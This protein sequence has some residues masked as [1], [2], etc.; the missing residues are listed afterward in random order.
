VIKQAMRKNQKGREKLKTLW[1]R[2]QPALQL[3]A[4]FRHAAGRQMRRTKSGGIAILSKV[5]A[6]GL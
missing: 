5:A 3:P 2:T 4:V 6:F 1:S